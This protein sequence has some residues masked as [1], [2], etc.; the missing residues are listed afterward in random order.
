MHSNTNINSLTSLQKYIRA[1]HAYHRIE[2]KTNLDIPTL[3]GTNLTALKQRLIHC[4]SLPASIKKQIEQEKTS[5]EAMLTPNEKKLYALL[6]NKTIF[7]N[8]ATPQADEIERSG[9]IHSTSSLKA[10]NISVHTHT[11]DSF[12][13]ESYVFFSLSYK[14]E[15]PLTVNFLNGCSTF[16]VNFDDL[17]R[18]EPDLMRGAWCSG[19]FYAYQNDEI[20]APITF[21]YQDVF[22]K[23]Q[24]AHY[25]NLRHLTKYYK[26]ITYTYADQSQA[27]IHLER[28]DE[29][30]ADQNIRPYHALKF[31]EYLRY[32]HPTIRLHILNSAAEE[33][34]LLDEIF[35]RIFTPGNV[36]FH[37]P[38]QFKFHMTLEQ[39]EFNDALANK[40]LLELMTNN[41]V[42][43]KES[44]SNPAV[45]FYRYVYSMSN[46]NCYQDV[47]L[48][49]IAVFTKNTKAV[50]LLLKAGFDPNHQ[51][52]NPQQ[53]LDSH[54]EKRTALQ[55]AV[56]IK[57]L[58][59][60]Y[61]LLG[62]R[63]LSKKFIM[64][65]SAYATKESLQTCLVL[66]YDESIFRLL[67]NH[68]PK[69]KEGLG[70][71][72]L[73]AA[74]HDNTSAVQ[75]L[76]EHGADVNKNYKL[77]QT[78]NNLHL[79]NESL[80]G[81]ALTMACHAGSLGAVKL[82]LLCKADCNLAALHQN[83]RFTNGDSP[84][85]AAIKGLQK[86]NIVST[87]TAARN[88]PAQS[89]LYIIDLL[90]EAGA[91]LSYC[92]DSGISVGDSLIQCLNK[93]SYSVLEKLLNKIVSSS[94][95][96]QLVFEPETP[97]KFVHA[98][99]TYANQNRELMM[100][101]AIKEV[102]EQTEID[103]PGGEE[104]FSYKQANSINY[105]IDITAQQTNLNL[106][107][108]IFRGQKSF[109]NNTSGATPSHLKN[110]TVFH[111]H[112]NKEPTMLKE[113]KN[114]HYSWISLSDLTLK[115]TEDALGITNL[116]YY[117]DKPLPLYICSFLAGLK[118]EKQ[119]H[120]YTRLSW[121]QP[122]ELHFA[123]IAKE[124][125][126]KPYPGKGAKL[127]LFSLP[128]ERISHGVQHALH[129]AIFTRIIVN[130]YKAM[131]HS[132]AI[133]LSNEKLHLLEITA[134]CH[135]TMRE[136]DREADRWEKQSAFYC[137][138]YLLRTGVEAKKAKRMAQAIINNEN[139]F[140]HRI[141]QSADCL[142]IPRVKPIFYFNRVCAFQDANGLFRCLLFDILKEII[143]LQA[144]QYDLKYD[145][146][147]QL[148][149]SDQILFTAKRTR[150]PEKPELKQAYEH[151]IAA[152]Q[153]MRDELKQFPLLYAYYCNKNLP[154]LN[155]SAEDI[156]FWQ[157]D[158]NDE[159]NTPRVGLY[160]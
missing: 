16:I 52:T 68:S 42:A 79:I 82:L 11:P 38:W 130:F 56:Q 65:F 5:P 77:S 39:R 83:G 123:V 124:T 104:I 134:F 101:I 66:N 59:M 84:L 120:Q 34:H 1:W 29:I 60:I 44:L 51:Y 153:N 64:F 136:N 107:E 63:Q 128:V 146:K 138:N 32:L 10:N 58:P 24:I 20:L 85:M 48:L 99:I 118:V 121:H 96:N 40:P 89:H 7:L 158:D 74:Y 129:V 78:C 6:I 73:L 157:D 122:P 4:N 36:E 131:N 125:Y 142:E 76:I 160:L 25:K 108:A 27:T 90:T 144:H 55:D 67:I 92:D 152:Y 110:R 149:N 94:R 50:G 132:K 100:L 113:Q 86:R 91:D 93:H 127:D 103:V 61:L 46:Q 119:L 70:E 33:N 17:L 126:L 115:R 21:Q 12:G 154:P 87:N 57:H 18:E 145:V 43:L 62:S 19:H 3:S 111:F 97:V 35:D 30:S 53:S 72:L 49:N 151:H 14:K 26:S 116:F 37:F 159:L 28:A 148:D 150:C 156:Q 95:T 23:V 13:Q 75:V 31:I 47:S 98:L 2:A 105:I 155:Y 71:L 41:L 69:N 140:Y 15:N 102:N 106:K 133:H 22:T 8:H 9:I 117:H 54:Q 139:D 135:D 112:F 147:V 143:A 109:K 81:T 114:E 137:E 88:L 80:E 45:K 141:I